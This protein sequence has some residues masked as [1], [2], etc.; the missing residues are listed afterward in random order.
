MVASEPGVIQKEPALIAVAGGY[1]LAWTRGLA[2]EVSLAGRLLD[3]NLTP[4]ED[5]YD[6]NKAPAVESARYRA[7]PRSVAVFVADI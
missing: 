2:G 1:F 7:A 6:R 3:T 4:P 5:I